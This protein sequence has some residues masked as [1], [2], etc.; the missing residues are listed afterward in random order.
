MLAI[1]HFSSYCLVICIALFLGDESGAFAT[2]ASLHFANLAI[3]SWGPCTSITFDNPTIPITFTGCKCATDVS[4][5][6]SFVALSSHLHYLIA[7]WWISVVNPP[8]LQDYS[9]LPYS[10]PAREAFL[11]CYTYCLV[12]CW[13][14][15][16]IR[17]IWQIRQICH[18]RRLQRGPSCLVICIALLL[19]DEFGKFA[20]FAVACISD[21]S[22]GNG[23]QVAIDFFKTLCNAAIKS[24]KADRFIYKP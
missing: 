24:I 10:S 19:A 4:N 22:T 13:R 6:A 17:H 21:V 20:T 2:V 11:S 1:S 23:H 15:W 7:W 5:F 3:F 9:N 8:H 12:A 16:R 18:T 14:I